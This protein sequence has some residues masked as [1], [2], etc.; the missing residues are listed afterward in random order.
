MRTPNAVEIKE[1]IQ[2]GDTIVVTGLLFVK[3]DA[4]LKI[5]SVKSNP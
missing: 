3:P 2:Q 1:G 5:R 4:K